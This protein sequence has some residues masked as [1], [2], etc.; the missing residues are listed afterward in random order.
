MDLN[1]DLPLDFVVEFGKTQGFLRV[2][3]LE[4]ETPSKIF[5]VL[6]QYLILLACSP[7]LNIGCLHNGSL[8][9]IPALYTGLFNSQ[10]L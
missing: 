4:R 8:L 2:F 3:R 1:P 10:A 5:G 6:N 9:T 7:Q